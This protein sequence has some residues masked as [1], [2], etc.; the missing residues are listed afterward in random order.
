MG[1]IQL[2]VKSQGTGIVQEGTELVEETAV[3]EISGCHNFLLC[4]TIVPLLL[5][6]RFEPLP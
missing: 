3:E 5:C 1:V 2:V 4:V 6:G